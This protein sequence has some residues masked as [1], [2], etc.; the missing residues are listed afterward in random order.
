MAVCS[1]GRGAEGTNSRVGARRGTCQKIF[2]RAVRFKSRNFNLQ[3][4]TSCELYDTMRLTKLRVTTHESR[5]IM[6]MPI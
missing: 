5:F 6:S 3:I 1:W 2:N 4:E